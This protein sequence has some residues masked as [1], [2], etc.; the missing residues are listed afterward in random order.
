MRRRE[1]ISALGSAVAMPFA[2]RGQERERVRRIGIIFPATADDAEFQA[3]LG[4]FHQGLQ[5]AGWII[6]RNV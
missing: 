2:A 4:A 5:E 1:F 3:R 6:G